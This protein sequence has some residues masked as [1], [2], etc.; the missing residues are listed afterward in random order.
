MSPVP[1]EQGNPDDV[2][3]EERLEASLEQLKQLHI[4]VCKRPSILHNY[5]HDE[6]ADS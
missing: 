1:E 5:R 4:K 6:F 3:E 2:R